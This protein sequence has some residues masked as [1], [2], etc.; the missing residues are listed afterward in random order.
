MDHLPHLS[1]LVESPYEKDDLDPAG[2]GDDRGDGVI[3]DGAPGGEEGR[4]RGDENTLLVDEGEEGAKEDVLGDGLEH[5]AGP[6]HVGERC[7]PGGE[8]RRK[9]PKKKTMM[10]QGTMV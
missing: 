9:E 3:A 2:G 8:V 10:K 6:D 4:R 1:D 7:G 5:P